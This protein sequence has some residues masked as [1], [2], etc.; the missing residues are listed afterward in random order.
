MPFL[1]NRTQQVAGTWGSGSID[2]D[3]NSFFAIVAINLDTGEFARVEHATGVTATTTSAHGFE[4]YARAA[5]NDQDLAIGENLYR[6][7]HNGARAEVVFEIEVAR[8]LRISED[9]QHVITSPPSIDFIDPLRAS[10]ETAT[11]VR[12]SF[13]RPYVVNPTESGVLYIMVENG[14][15][16]FTSNPTITVSPAVAARARRP[17]RYTPGAFVTRIALDEPRDRLHVR[18]D[19]YGVW[20]RW[21]LRCDGQ[22]LFRGVLDHLPGLRERFWRIAYFATAHFDLER[23]LDDTFRWRPHVPSVF[24]CRRPDRDGPRLRAVL[25]AAVPRV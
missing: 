9:G 24:Q 12:V 15:T 4:F 22:G 2:L 16:G 11:N 17:A 14:G 8:A 3:A 13:Q 18:P 1:A 23:A 21:R 6:N 10:L 5:S 20:R 19:G 25:Y 7:L